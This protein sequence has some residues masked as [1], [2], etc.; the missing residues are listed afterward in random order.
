MLVND[1]ILGNGSVS[2]VQTTDV[3]MV[4]LNV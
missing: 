2:V 4:S 3:M 1:G